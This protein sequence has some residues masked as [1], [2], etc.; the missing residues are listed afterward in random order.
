MLGLLSNLIG[1]NMKFQT[2]DSSLVTWYIMEGDKH[3]DYKRTYCTDGDGILQLI[4]RLDGSFELVDQLDIVKTWHDVDGEE[5]FL[6]ILEEVQKYL[7]ATYHEIF[8]NAM[9]WRDEPTT[10]QARQDM[11]AALG[12]AHLNQ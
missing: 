12:Y 6:L 5:E 8:E 9:H 11:N 3:D 2:I 7:A 4:E 10:D 1:V